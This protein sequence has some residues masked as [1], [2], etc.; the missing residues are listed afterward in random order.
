[1]ADI[2]TI[3]GCQKCGSASLTCKYN[4]FG[5]GE[6]QIHSWEHKCLDCGHRLT[7]AYRTD[8]EDIVFADEDVDHC[9]YCGRSPV[10]AE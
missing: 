9:P 7:T 3:G 1:M 4:F 8:D 6:L 10:E 2:Q 5:E